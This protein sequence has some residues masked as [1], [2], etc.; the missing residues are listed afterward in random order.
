MCRCCAEGVTCSAATCSGVIEAEEMRRTD[1]W[2]RTCA[3]CTRG[4]VSIAWAVARPGVEEGA[5]EASALSP[6]RV[7]AADVRGGVCGACSPKE[8]AIGSAANGGGD[9]MRTAKAHASVGKEQW[10]VQRKAADETS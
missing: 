8:C 9:D 6:K 10:Q 1:D 5:D 3:K 7:I 4:G 2:R